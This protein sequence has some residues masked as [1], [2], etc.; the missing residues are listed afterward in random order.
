MDV[1][2]TGGN[3]MAHRTAALKRTARHG[4]GRGQ[5]QRTHAYKV[6]GRA[7]RAKGFAEASIVVGCLLLAGRG[8]SQVRATA[9]PL[10][11]S[12]RLFEKLRVRPMRHPACSTSVT[13]SR[14]YTLPV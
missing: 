7:S 11:A 3:P 13:T 14:R 2:V 9:H 12:R 6:D 4:F 5:Q 1:P 10:P 8:L